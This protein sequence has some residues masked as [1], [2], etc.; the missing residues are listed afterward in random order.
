MKPCVQ[1]RGPASACCARLSLSINSGRLGDM[2]AANMRH[3]NA[4]IAELARA[5]RQ[6]PPG[7][8]TSR[9]C[10]TPSRRRCA[11]SA[12][13]PG[14]PSSPASTKHPPP[15]RETGPPPHHSNRPD[16]AP[17]APISAAPHFFHLTP[18]PASA[19]RRFW[20][21]DWLS[22]LHQRVAR[23][24]FQL[25]HNVPGPPC[26]PPHLSPARFLARPAR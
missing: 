14:R 4:Q 6:P 8:G 26:A 17:P 19:V 18:A 12:S 5:R 13:R 3:T 10:G 9:G 22:P 21:E 20:P 24:S 11:A 23:T 2:V 7:P 16:T 25:P 1:H 15:S